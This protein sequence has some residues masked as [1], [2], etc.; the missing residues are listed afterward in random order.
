MTDDIIIS[1]CVEG[2]KVKLSFAEDEI[3]EPLPYDIALMFSKVI[4]DKG[5]DDKAVVENM[6]ELLKV[7]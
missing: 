4:R 7:K 2:I 6:Q 3:D 1:Y 5:F